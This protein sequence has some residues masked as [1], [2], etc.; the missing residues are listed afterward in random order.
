M[1]I[2][3]YGQLIGYFIPAA[4]IVIACGGGFS[5]QKIVGPFDVWGG[6]WSWIV[7]IAL[8]ALI[9]RIALVEAR[10]SVEREFGGIGS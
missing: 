10:L 9:V 2:D 8:I 5:S 7:A 4:M 6:V 3:R 1:N